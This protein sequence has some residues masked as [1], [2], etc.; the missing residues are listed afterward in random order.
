MCF[1]FDIR[2]TVLNYPTVELPFFTAK[3]VHF[4]FRQGNRQGSW[5]IMCP[6]FLTLQETPSRYHVLVKDLFA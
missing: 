3:Y 4:T 5:K 2:N 6:I 1:Y